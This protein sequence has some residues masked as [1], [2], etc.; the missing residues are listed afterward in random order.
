LD[1]SVSLLP[2]GRSVL[3]LVI[4]LL[5]VLVFEG[6][7]STFACFVFVNSFGDLGSISMFTIRIGYGSGL[8]F[9]ILVL[10]LL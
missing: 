6:S 5:L 10:I 9:L 8:L 3:L 4:V 7:G 2:I 1:V